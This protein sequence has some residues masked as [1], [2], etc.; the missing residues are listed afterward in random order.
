MSYKEYIEKHP[1]V[2]DIV[3]PQFYNYVHAMGKFSTNKYQALWD[4]NTEFNIKKIYPKHSTLLEAFRGFGKN[5]AVVFIGAGPSF[6]NNKDTLKELFQYNS[7]FTANEM[8]FIFMASN[9]QFKPLLKMGITPHFVMLTDA[10]DHLYDQLCTKIPQSAKNCVLVP[11]FHCSPKITKAWHRQGRKICF[12]GARQDELPQIL[13]DTFKDKAENVC[14]PHAG[15][16]SNVAFLA[17]LRISGST[18]F[19]TVGNDLSFP[20]EADDKKRE[21]T[22]YAAGDYTSTEKKKGVDEAAQ[23]FAWMGFEYT[24]MLSPDNRPIINLKPVMTTKQF[25]AYKLWLESSLATWEHTT[26]EPFRYINCSESGIVGVLAKEHNPA[27]YKD[28]NNFQLLDE[29]CPKK[30]GTR[31]LD[32]AVQEFLKARSVLWQEKVAMRNAV[33]NVGV[34]PQEMGGVRDVGPGQLHL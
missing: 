2:G 12:Y 25:F 33:G 22:Y 18:V 15:N 17:T 6:N 20:F 16:V 10:G 24:D 14:V 11:S 26:R 21:D 1:Y 28:I 3:P 19:M 29:V 23:K 4:Q 9:H 31:T 27:K 34:L 7:Q 13:K 32:R 5:K 8:P 30:Y